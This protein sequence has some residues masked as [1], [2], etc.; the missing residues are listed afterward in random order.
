MLGPE[1]SLEL[2]LDP[3]TGQDLFRTS[4]F[5]SGVTKVICPEDYLKTYNEAITALFPELRI[6]GGFEYYDAL[7]LGV[8]EAITGKKTP[9]QA[10]DEVAKK[11][12]EITNRL[13][14]EEQLVKY[15]AAMGL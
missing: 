13:G 9:K 8:Q 7:D 15:R 3:G 4:H 6:P 2:V 11:W 1:T 14:R 12:D 10:L 5:E